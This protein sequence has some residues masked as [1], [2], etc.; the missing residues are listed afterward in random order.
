M[1]LP[2]IGV[3]GPG[4]QAAA[5]T[6]EQS[7]QLGYLIGQRGWVVLSGGRNVGVM[8]AV[9]RGAKDANGLVVGILPDG[10]RS[11]LS[12]FVDIAIVTDLGNARNNINVLSSDI[13]VALEGGMGT[14]SEVALALKSGKPVLL[15]NWSD[16]ARTWLVSASPL[17]TIVSTPE[18][19]VTQVAH[20]LDSTF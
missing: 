14:L 15:L 16:A 5:P 12:P 13:V 18:E 10:D 9:S 4:D 8:E 7:Y 6:I 11:R 3:M 1:P 17:I 2:I 20:I 19:A